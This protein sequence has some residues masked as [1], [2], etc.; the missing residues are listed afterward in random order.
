MRS[1]TLLLFA[2]KRK[3]DIGAPVL[4]ART[5]AFTNSGPSTIKSTLARRLD[6]PLRKPTMGD[7]AFDG[8]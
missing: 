1:E 3:S 7:A 6:E 4:S 2:L 5:V 8:S